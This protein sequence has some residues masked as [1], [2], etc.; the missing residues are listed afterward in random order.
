MHDLLS[1]NHFLGLEVLHHVAHE[2][3]GHDTVVA[4][5]WPLVASVYFNQRWVES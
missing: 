5:A 2:F 4:N 1:V 3:K